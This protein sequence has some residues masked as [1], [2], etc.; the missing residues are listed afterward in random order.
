M[1]KDEFDELV[2]DAIDRIMGD[3]R[4]GAIQASDGT[5][6][7]VMSANGWFSTKDR[8]CEHNK[9]TRGEAVAA[10]AYELNEAREH[11]RKV[12][13]EPRQSAMRKVWGLPEEV[14]GEKET[15]GLAVDH[16]DQP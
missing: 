16:R 10:A 14:P 3:N 4:V 6:I 15:S 5:F 2:N 11:L 13:N 1:N 7:P 8:V 12:L 9:P